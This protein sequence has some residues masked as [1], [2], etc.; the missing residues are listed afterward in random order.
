MFRL[1]RIQKTDYPVVFLPGIFGSIGDD[2][3]PGTG[4]MRFGLAE[5]FYRPIIEN[6]NQMGYVEGKNLFIA[7]YDWK[8]NSKYN[9]Y[10]YLIPT[11][12]KAKQ[13]NQTSKVI[14]IC[15]SMGGLVARSY[16]QEKG[17]EFDVSKLIMMGTP[18]TGSVKA[19]YFWS[20]GEIPY[21]NFKSNLIYNILWA[22]FIWYLRMYYKETDTLKLARM[23]FPS[24]EELIPSREYGNY[25]FFESED[26]NKKFY[27]IEKMKIQNNYL[28]FMNKRQNIFKKFGIRVYL[29]VGIGFKTTRFLCVSQN[30][31]RSRMWSDGE[32]KYET[33]TYFGDGTVTSSSVQLVSGDTRYI[34]SNHTDMLKDSGNILANILNKRNRFRI[35]KSKEYEIDNFYSILAKNISEIKISFKD[36]F[37]NIKDLKG[38]SILVEKLGNDDYWIIINNKEN[39][40]IKIALSRTRNKFGKIVVFKNIDGKLKRIQEKIITGS[41]ILDIDA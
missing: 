25:L 13:I 5:P 19:Y 9:A 27:P 24:I 23:Y 7:Y 36:N 12:K 2:I 16:I 37:V 38:D 33:S 6:L 14:L 21:E 1:R 39:I 22:G 8:M 35:K 31:V 41:G 20:G 3:F 18:N 29:I 15:H 40:P 30:N 4:E 26:T 32:P 10:K 11:I 17:Y 28:S 34:N